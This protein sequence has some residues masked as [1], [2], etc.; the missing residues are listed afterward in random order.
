MWLRDAAVIHGFILPIPGS[1]GAQATMAQLIK[2]GLWIHTGKLK[3]EDITPGN[4]IVWRRP[5]PESWTGHIGVTVDYDPATRLITT[6]EGNSGP[7][8]DRVAINTRRSLD[9]PLLLGVGDWD[10]LEPPPGPSEDL[11][12]AE[13]T[14]S[15][16]DVLEYD[17][18]HLF[19][20]WMGLD[21]LAQPGGHVSAEQDCSGL[22]ISSWQRPDTLHWDVIAQR[23]AFVIC[24]ATYGEKLDKHF[25]SHSKRIGNTS[26]TFGAYHFIRTSQHWAAQLDVFCT[27]LDHVGYGGS[28]LLPVLD[29]E[30]NKFDPWEPSKLLNYSE[31]MVEVLVSRYGGAMLYIS[32]SI[33]AELGAPKLFREH[34]IWIAHY[35]VESPRWDSD[36]V[37]WQSSGSYRGP[38]ADGPL[39][40]N[41][42]K[43]LPL[44]G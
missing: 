28:D 44:C 18:D 19:A 23:H 6:I 7:A 25:M 36:W 17:A 39:D 33:D 15:G 16:S 41:Q 8:A 12:E 37:I 10:A 2:A 26:L 20:R 38:E 40:I 22:D 24:R 14:H 35:G 29:I 43:S 31:N 21:K 13:P 5:G 4:V 9:D 32:P 11:F 3:G 30:R 1:P 42:A 27:A 34:P